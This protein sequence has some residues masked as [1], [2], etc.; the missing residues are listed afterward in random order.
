VS[1]SPLRPGRLDAG[2]DRLED[3]VEALD[4]GVRPADHQAKAPVETED[5][6]AGAA[7]DVVDALLANHLRPAHVVPVVGVAAVDDRVALVEDLGDFL[8]GR[9]GYVARRD[10]DP[11]GARSFELLRQ[12]LQGGRTGRPLTRELLDRVRVDV[13]DDAVVSITHQPPDE[14]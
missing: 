4:R 5:A 8:D 3:R 11:D 9:L 12:L 6:A 7:I 10:H 2:S 13:V 1:G 14:V